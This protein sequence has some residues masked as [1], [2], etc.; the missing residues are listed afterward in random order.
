MDFLLDNDV[1]K[2]LRAEII[3]WTRFLMEHDISNVSK[4]QVYEKCY[5]S[6]YDLLPTAYCLY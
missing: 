1:P 4:K 6:T 2:M 3:Q 5:T